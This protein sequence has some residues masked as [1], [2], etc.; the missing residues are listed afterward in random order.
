MP[1]ERKLATIRRITEINPIEGAD[2]IEAISIGGWTVVAQKAMGY[3]VN[4]LVVYLEIDAFVPTEVAPFLTQEGKEPKE[5]LGIKGERLRTKKLKGVVSQG[6]LLPLEVA[7]QR[8]VESDLDSGEE[9]C[10]VFFEGADVTDLFGI[11][12]WQPPAEFRS[13]DAKGTF[14]SFI[15]KTDQ[16]RIQ[17]LSREFDKYKEAAELWEITEKLDGS[18]MTV[19]FKDGNVGVCSRNL[20]LKEDL[21][22]T[23]W[24]CAVDS[25]AVDELKKFQ[26][27]LALQGELIGP[28]IQ[29]NKYNLQK[30]EYHIYDIFDIAKQEYLL[31]EE[32]YK[33]VQ[34][35]QLMHCPVLEV[36]D[37]QFQ[38]IP[39]ILAYAEGKSRLNPK[40]ERE[41]VVFKNMQ[42]STSFKAIS[43]KWLIKF[44]E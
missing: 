29:G 24:G 16:E 39:D 36:Q 5:Y 35:M 40:T 38:G 12:K 15:P 33:V 32:R 4:D 14:P 23:F 7:V 34:A 30:H 27:E 37:L 42:S 41:G 31:P 20:E 21:E 28:G 1:S 43:N 25:G 18:S 8:F 44:D 22:N 2:L 13:A 17:N 26:Q 11:I 9:L 10:E 19:F 6:L 3:K